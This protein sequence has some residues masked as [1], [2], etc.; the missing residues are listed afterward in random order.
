METI[1]STIVGGKYESVIDALETALR[2]CPAELWET[3]LW[4][5]RKDQPYVWP[6]RTVDAREGDDAKDSERLLQVYSAFWNVAYHTLFH[7]D[8]YLSGAASPFT[9]P[10]PFREDEH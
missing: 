1:W 5:V 9:P 7:L 10:P 3:S 2:D 4:Q 8:F 6:V